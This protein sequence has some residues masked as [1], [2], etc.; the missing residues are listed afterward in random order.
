[1]DHFQHLSAPKAGVWSHRVTLALAARK[2]ASIVPKG[3]LSQVCY[4]TEQSQSVPGTAQGPAPL[5]NLQPL[6]EGKTRRE[7]ADT[8][9]EGENT[10][11][12]RVVKSGTIGS[13]DR[14][15]PKVTG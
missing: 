5:S 13:M 15:K 10:V 12:S 11:G 6:E 3:G 1:M 2:S 7:N 8:H 4:G 14:M 9:R